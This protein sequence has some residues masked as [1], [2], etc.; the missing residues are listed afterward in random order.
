VRTRAEFG[1]GT[2]KDGTPA[3]RA[4]T[5]GGAEGLPHSGHTPSVLSIL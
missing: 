3:P 2:H 4:G 5:G 1:M